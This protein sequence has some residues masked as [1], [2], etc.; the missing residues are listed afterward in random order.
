MTHPFGPNHRI[1]TLDVMTKQT[2]EEDMNH[3][4]T[5]MSEDMTTSGDPNLNSDNSSNFEW[6]YSMRR[7]MQQIIPHLWLGPY[8]SALKARE[9]DLCR[10]GITHIICVRQEIESHWIRPNFPNRHYLTLDIADTPTQNIIHHFPE[11]TKF[12]DDCLRQN[13]SV[14][15]HGNAGISRSAALVIAYVMEKQN[16]TANQ[17]IRVVQSKRFCIFPNEG[18]R[19]QLQEYEPILQARGIPLSSEGGMKR[20]LSDEDSENMDTNQIPFNSMDS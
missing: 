13:G 2:T 12:I 6:E 3:N 20:P 10:V 5:Q 18:F 7:Q 14:L 11:V 1:Q 16:L 19:Q 8:A 15:V 17:A 4:E 9:E